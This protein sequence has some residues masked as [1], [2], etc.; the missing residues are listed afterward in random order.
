M[1]HTRDNAVAI[2]SD[3]QK[4][5]TDFYEA[6]EL[7][8][9]NKKLEGYGRV[10]K[11]GDIPEWYTDQ[12]GYQDVFLDDNIDASFSFLSSEES[13]T[14]DEYYF[15]NDVKVVVIVN[16]EKLFG[17]GEGRNDKM[18]ERD[19][20]ELLRTISRKRYQIT[21]TE[22]GLDR[23]YSGYD[24]SNITRDDLHPFHIFAV[25]MNLRYQIK[26]KC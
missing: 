18:A 7:R 23:I 6:L 20:V 3:I 13:A 15:T 10:Y 4:I 12:K 16:L 21:G 26:D 9:P 1:N 14:E 11:N 2:D 22:T 8:W 24:I 5:Q 19:A 25:N 17:S